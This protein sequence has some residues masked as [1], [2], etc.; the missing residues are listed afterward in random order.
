MGIYSCL[1]RV[2]KTTCSRFSLSPPWWQAALPLPKDQPERL[3]A[4]LPMAHPL[5]HTNP[6]LT[7]L[8]NSHLNLLPTNMVSRMTTPVQVS[9]SLN[10]K[11][12][13]V[14]LLVNTV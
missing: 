9:T 7:Q 10:P 8:K 12:P 14:L 6:L 2:P 1:F 3:L 13:R 11:T 5:P 4:P